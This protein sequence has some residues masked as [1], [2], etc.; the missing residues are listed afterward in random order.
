MPDSLVVSVPDARL[1]YAVGDVPD[2]VEI[3][4]WDFQ[5]D[6]PRSRIDL[7]VPPYMGGSSRLGRVGEVENTLVQSQSIGYD[8]VEDLLPD[9][10]TY[11]NA[12]TVHETATAELALTLTL[13]AQRGLPQFVRDAESGTWKSRMHPGLA[14][15]RVMILGYGGVGRAI[16]DRLLPFEVEV[17]RVASKPRSD[18]RGHVYGTDD[19]PE[20]L[21]DLDIV[22]VVTPLTPSTAGLVGDDVLSALPDGALVV[23]V[24][25]GQVADTDA[26]VSHATEGRIRLALDVT[27]PEPLPQDHP[28]WSL[29]NVLISP[30]VG[31]ASGAMLPR[32]AALIR[33]QI[34]HLLA[35]ED[36]ENIVLRT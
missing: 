16:E 21:P 28:L 14:D 9:G 20:L 3:V 15:K 36:P 30:H 22:I 8:G 24:A 25:R 7:I 34:G 13:A 19:L 33:R 29:E 6:P 17:V 35:G 26:L 23:N 2:G 5:S 18:D 11:A 31:G 12:T 4:E 32:M 27:D 10:I 1:A